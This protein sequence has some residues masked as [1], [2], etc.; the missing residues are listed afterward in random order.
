MEILKRAY[1]LE[2]IDEIDIVI[3]R[4]TELHIAIE[5]EKI[6]R[7]TKINDKDKVPEGTEIAE[8]LEQIR[9]TEDIL[10]LAELKYINAHKNEVLHLALKEMK[11]Y[12]GDPIKYATEND[13]FSLYI[14]ML[15]G[16]WEVRTASKYL[17]DLVACTDE[18]IDRTIG[19]MIAECY[20]VV[21]YKCF[22]GNI[23]YLKE[24]I[25]KDGISEFSTLAY[26]QVLTMFWIFDQNNLPELRDYLEQLFIKRP[27]TASQITG[28]IMEHHKDEL[29]PITEKCIASEFY[30]PSI[31]GDREEYMFH[32][33]DFSNMETDRYLN[34]L[35]IHWRV[36]QVS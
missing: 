25:E 8:I 33:N 35:P 17:I 31:Y 19:D 27:E 20:S 13:F 1:Y 6:E 23:D 26:L 28:V 3:E 29:L 21:L 16:Q 10:P 30:D 4:M 22:D 5:K 11:E 14:P 15:L 9:K 7:F 36:V 32:F 24:M 18:E 12:A 2:S 34:Y